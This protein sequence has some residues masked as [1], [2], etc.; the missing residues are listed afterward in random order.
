AYKGSSQDPWTTTTFVNE[1]PTSPGSLVAHFIRNTVLPTAGRT[2]RFAPSV[3]PANDLAIEDI[4][5]QGKVSLASG[6]PHQV[7]AVIKNVGTATATNKTI[8]LVIT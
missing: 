1:D 7:K 6:A 8:T 3:I 2:Y 4:F 5:T